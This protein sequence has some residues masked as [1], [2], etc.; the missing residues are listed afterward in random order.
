M[1]ANSKFLLEQAMEGNYA[2]PHANIMDQHTIKAYIST[3]NELQMPLILG[4]AECH[5]PYISMEEASVLGKYYAEKTN[6]P[7]VLHLDHGSSFQTVKEAIAFGFTSVMFDGSMLPFEENVKLSK[8]IVDYAHKFGVTVESELGHVGN[9]SDYLS[10]G[11]NLKNLY[12][13]PEDAKRFIELTNVDSLA[14]AIGTA[15]GEYV[16]VPEIDYERLYILRKELSIPLVL[17]GSSGTGLDKIAKCIDGGINKVNICT[18]LLK[19][20]QNYFVN[21]ASKLL[22]D[23]LSVGVEEAV[24]DC[25]KQYYQALRTK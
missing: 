9:G 25:L 21:D 6:M 13:N 12:T 22:Y 4:W 16:G 8:E 19:A 24:S 7:V 1:L 3:C 17:H 2:I 20:A 23:K 10:E 5:A 18:D 14:V 11:V 15:H